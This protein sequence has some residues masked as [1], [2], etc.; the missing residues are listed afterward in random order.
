MLPRA[1]AVGGVFALGLVGL[2]SGACTDDPSEAVDAGVDAPF[3]DVYIAIPPSPPRDAEPEYVDTT[4]PSRVTNLVATAETHTSVT[5]AWTAP[6]DEV[7]ELDTATSVARY[8][9]AWSLTPITTPAEL[10]AAT[11]ISAPTPLD[12]NTPQSFTVTGLPVAT[13]L[14]FAMRAFD[15]SGNAGS[16][17]ND[18]IVTT[19]TRATF[20]VSEVAPAN[21]LAEGGDFVELVATTAGSAADLEVRHSSTSA[22]ALL[23]KLGALDVVVGDRIVV[24]TIGLPAPGGFVQEDTT[25]DRT[26]STEQFASTEAFDV[27]SAVDSLVQTNSVISVNDG[28][29]YQDAV[30]YS[31]RAEDASAASMT[32]FAN[33]HAAGAWTFTTAPIDGANDCPTLLEAVNVNASSSTAPSC[34]GWPGFLGASSSIQRNGVTDT[35]TRQDFFVATQTRGAANAPFC[36]TEGA[37]LALTE[38]NPNADLVELT[39]TQGG[40]LR[41]FTV[42]RDPRV[43]DNGTLISTLGPICAAAGDVIVVHLGAAAGTPSETTAKDQHPIATQPSFYDGAWDVASTSGASALPTDTSLVLAVR[44]PGS[45]YVEAAALSNMTTPAGSTYEQALAFVQG[46][47]LWLPASCGGVSPCTGTTTPT[48]QG[49]AASWNG[50]GA[51]AADA[52]CR[53]SAP[54]SAREAASWSVGASSFGL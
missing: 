26:S 53:R 40:S 7:V 48:A 36:A 33:A 13:E 46:L 52:S 22:S 31:S 4:P 39:A 5:L 38:V 54:A 50:A 9:L 47:G 16:V 32:A 8:E 18:A 15:R 44:D 35:N 49:V 51:L 27:Y 3:I 10:A 29:T 43:G 28:A 42:R 2:V 21:T 24:H 37:T 17:S 25:K 45:V 12:Y 41:G 34:G 1:L 19:K 23:Y 6:V 14:H 30:A 20:L 11:S